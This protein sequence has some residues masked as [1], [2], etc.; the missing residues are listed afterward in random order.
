ML[1][2]RILDYAR[3]PTGPNAKQAAALHTQENVH[4]T[5]QMEEMIV[6]HNSRVSVSIDRSARD[7]TP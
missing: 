6:S 3:N 2:F 1:S 5:N 4:A 7:L